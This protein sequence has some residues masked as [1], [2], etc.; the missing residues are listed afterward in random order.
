MLERRKV[1]IKGVRW[2][3]GDGKS[4]DI[5]K[6]SWYHET[7]ISM[8]AVTERMGHGLLLSL[9]EETNGIKRRWPG[10]M[11]V[12]QL[13]G[14]VV[15]TIGT[16]GAEGQGGGARTDQWSAMATLEVSE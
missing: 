11:N 7:P 6:D 15:S 14:L 9:L 2:R 3:V 5:W 10:C 12:E 13:Q 1:L 4:I 16:T 8:F